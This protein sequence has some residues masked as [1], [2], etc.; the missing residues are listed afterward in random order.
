[1]SILLTGASGLI[2]IDLAYRLSH[3]YKVFGVYRTKKKLK[4]IKNVIWIKHDFRKKFNK[5]LRPTPK[6]IVH[7]AVDQKYSKQN[8]YKYLECNLKIF[9]NIINFSLK[10][11]VKL[12]VNFSSI[13]VYGNINN[14]LVNE[15]YKPKNQNPYGLIKDL[16]E[17]KL[18]GTKIN[19]INIRLPGVLCEPSLN[20]NKRPWLNEIFAKMQKNKVIYV[21]NIN[22]KFNNLINTDEIAKFLKFL[23]KKNIIIRDTFNFA[24]TKPII[25]QKL[26]NIAK[27][28]LYSKSKIYNFKSSK[29]NSFYIS[30]S[31]IEKKL[32]YKI[33]CSKKILDKHLE[34][35]IKL[36]KSHGS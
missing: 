29:R 6:Y 5:K 3:N 10:N 16:S 13:D 18:Y 2:G 1:M 23:I 17:K 22:G 9:D 20:S 26:L 21:H 36:K 31:K 25:L 28:K 15:N 12:F 35:F 19:F 11:N 8:M 14:K 34:N 32:N 27:Q 30:T 24:C 7:C 33:E 4:K